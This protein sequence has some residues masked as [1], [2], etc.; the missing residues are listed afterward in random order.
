[1]IAIMH[2]KDYCTTK[3]SIKD[4]KFPNTYAKVL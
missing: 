4:L 3:N 2:D 1:M